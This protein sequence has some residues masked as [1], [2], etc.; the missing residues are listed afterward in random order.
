[1]KIVIVES[2]ERTREIISK[3]VKRAY[4]EAVIAGMARNG[5]EGYELI[6]TE[7]PEIVIMDIRLPGMSGLTMLRRLRAEKIYA[8]V[9]IITEDTDF[10]HARQAITLGV[11][12]YM[13]KPVRPLQLKSC[14]SGQGEN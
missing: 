1:M 7:M 9:I 13:L 8:R 12:D 4:P 14:Q 10:E 5:R 3:T 6:R 2:D 11:D